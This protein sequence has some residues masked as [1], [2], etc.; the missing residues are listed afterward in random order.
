MEESKYKQASQAIKNFSN[1][2]REHHGNYAYTTGYY[3][4]VILELMEYVDDKHRERV[5]RQIE[6]T[7]ADFEKKKIEAVLRA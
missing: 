7:T 5:V 6:A 1:I 3:E 2:T 4:S